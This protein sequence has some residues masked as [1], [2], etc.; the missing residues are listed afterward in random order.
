MSADPVCAP[1]YQKR[2][3][4]EELRQWILRRLGAPV[5]KVELC[6]ENVSDAVEQARRWFAAKKG[7]KKFFK[8]QALP[9]KVDYLL[10]CQ[11]DQVLEVA[12]EESKNDLSL[13]YSPFTLPDE[14]IPYS[15]F[16]TGGVSGGIYSDYVQT[17]QYIEMAKRIL[18]A[19]LDYRFDQDS[20]TL[21]LSPPPSVAKF[22]ILQAKVHFVKIEELSERDHDLLKRYALACAREDL[23]WIRGKYDSYPG[24]QGTVQL[25]ADRL[26]QRAQ[27]E[28]EKLEEEIAGSAGPMGFLVG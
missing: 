23:A 17:L 13:V 24:A 3:N 7:V 28:K 15:V 14:A 2:M 12:F 21:Y 5:Q 10:D 19:E 16:A 8:F 22:V 25:D 1:V 9:N 26:L 6:E 27:E 4:C 18:S 11:I 20:R